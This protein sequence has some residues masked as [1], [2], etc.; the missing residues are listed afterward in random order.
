MSDLFRA[1][2]IFTGV[3]GVRARVC[4]HSWNITGRGVNCERGSK[5]VHTVTSFTKK[6]TKTRN[7]KVLHAGQTECTVV[8]FSQFINNYF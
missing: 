8:L 6:Q 3:W 4:T 1:S 2:N 7:I 5:A